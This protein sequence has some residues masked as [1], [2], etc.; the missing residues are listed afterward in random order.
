MNLLNDASMFSRNGGGLV[1]VAWMWMKKDW[2]VSVT[3]SYREGN[4][5]VDSPTDFDLRMSDSFIFWN[6][7]SNFVGLYVLEDL[8]RSARF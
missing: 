3:H 4:R 6:S 7:A 1:N 2:I 5:V 8:M